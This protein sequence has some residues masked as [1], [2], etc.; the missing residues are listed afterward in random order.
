VRSYKKEK[1]KQNKQTKKK[2]RGEE[3][4]IIIILGWK[5]KN[6]YKEIGTTTTWF[7]TQKKKKSFSKPNP[8]IILHIKPSQ[9]LIKFYL[10]LATL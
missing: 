8:L 9:N 1:T 2:S 6:K 3:K 10:K 4:Y 5:F 7:R